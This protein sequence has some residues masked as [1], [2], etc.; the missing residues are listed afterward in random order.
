M[1]LA[2]ILALSTILT[3]ACGTAPPAEQSEVVNATAKGTEH[4]G[5]D[6]GDTKKMDHGDATKMDHGAMN[7]MDHSAMKGAYACPMHPD[8]T[9]DHAGECP[10]CGMA[11]VKGDADDHA[12]HE[13]EAP[14]DEH[15]APAEGHEGH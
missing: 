11:L 9:S 5:M 12:G 13:H 8:V 7:G 3:A 4:E 2:S 15:K 6:H 10:K 1:R 14:A